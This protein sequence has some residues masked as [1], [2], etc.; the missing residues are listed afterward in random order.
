VA[1][2][3]TCLEIQNQVTRAGLPCA[4]P[5]TAATELDDLVVHAEQWRPGGRVRPEDGLE[6]ATDSAQ[7]LATVMRVTMAADQ[8]PRT[9][10]PNPIWVRWNHAA[11]SPWP[12]SDIVDAQQASTGITLPTWL[13]ELQLRIHARLRQTSLPL[14]IGHADWE[15]QNL[16]WDGQSIHTVHDWDSLAALPEAAL[17]GAAAGAFASTDPP[18]LVPVASSERFLAA[19]QDAFGR[20]LTEEEVEIAWAASMY[21]AAHNARGEVLFNNPLV[22][23]DALR[24]QAAE[25]LRRAGA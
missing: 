23:S 8:E 24:A 6:H 2:V 25:R 4:K 14:V 9:V 11:T 7:A 18:T 3:Q 20:R 19:Y 16:R 17:V 13:E 21:T 12:R 10:E 5:L 15:A 22:A 1:R